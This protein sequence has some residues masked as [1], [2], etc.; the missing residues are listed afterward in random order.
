M[1][2]E[3]AYIAFD[4]DGQHKLFL[5]KDV[6]PPHVFGPKDLNGI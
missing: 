5:L 2:N 6:L 4:R 3:G 1:G